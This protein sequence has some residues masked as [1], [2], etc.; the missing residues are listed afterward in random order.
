MKTDKSKLTET[1]AEPY[2]H[3]RLPK[4]FQ[5]SYTDLSYHLF[6]IEQL[7]VCCEGESGRMA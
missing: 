4:A 7:T 1:H 2:S 3:P 5:Q 6:W